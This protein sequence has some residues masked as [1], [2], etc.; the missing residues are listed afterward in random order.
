MTTATKRKKAPKPKNAAKP[1]ADARQK[2]LVKSLRGSMSW[3]N[4]TVDEYLREKHAETDAENN[5]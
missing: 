4:I 2:A 1:T 3:L 5:R